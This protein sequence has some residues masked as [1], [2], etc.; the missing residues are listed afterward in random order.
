MIFSF[1]GFWMGN[2]YAAIIN[3]LFKIIDITYNSKVG[4]SF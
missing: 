2:K 1:E 3:A 4:S